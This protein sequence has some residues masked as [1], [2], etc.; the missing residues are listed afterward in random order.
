MDKLPFRQVHLDFH[1]SEYM[2]DVGSEFSEENFRN[3]LILGHISSITLFS[4]CHHGWSYHETKVNKMHPTLKTNLLK[5]QL[6]VCK[7]L[8]VRAQIYISAGL[9]ERKA[10]IYPEFR[11]E[12]RNQDNTLLGAHWHGLCLN[13]DN[14]ISMLKA[15][16]AEVM[17]DFK[18]LF[19]GIFIDICWPSPCVCPCCI[20]SMCDLGLNPENPDDVEKHRKIVYFKYTKILNSEILKHDKNMAVFYNCGNLPRNDRNVVYSNTQH[21]EL[22]SLPTGG[23]GYDHFPMSAAYSRVVGREFLGMTGKFHKSWGE[24]GGYKHPNALIYETALSIA[25]GAK[26]SI[27]DQLHP[28]GKFDEATYKLIGAAYSE[29]E[30]KE[31]WC[32]DVTAVA[33][34]AI[35]TTY[36][37]DTRNI[38]PDIGANRILLEGKYLYNIIDN[39]CDF[40]NYKIII[41][42]DCVM[43]DE[44][45]SEKT[46]IY[47]KN[48]GKIL[49]SGKSGLNHNDEFFKYFGIKYSGKSEYDSSYLIPAYNMMPNGSA[50]YLMYKRGHI[51]KSENEN[52]KIMAYMQ[53][54]YFNRSFR[55][56]CSHQNTPNDPKSRLPGAIIADNNIAYIAWDIFS[57]YWEHGAYHQKRIVCDIL[58][59]LLENNK[60]LETTLASNGVVTLMEQKKQKRY[61]NHLLYAVTKL[62]GNTEVI[63]DAAEIINTKVSIKLP[64]KPSRV[65]F[66]PD[67][68]DIP[69]TYENGKLS[70]TIDRF[71]LHGMVVIDK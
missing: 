67:N 25:N 66:A 71:V 14:Y 29:I 45:L 57:E 37:D 41:F 60:T 6:L 70:Y 30:K 34:I 12:V 33:D 47:L 51:I 43:F 50:P 8:G 5:R 22:E 69:Y 36:T 23:W 28:L 58:D 27:G 46:K 15:E 48:G 4:K 65:Y 32:G 31:K 59:I 39:Y 44:H 3:A 64:Q 10:V 40:S 52:V 61:V 56:F 24:F 54:S 7:E 68:I 1:T 13:N 42:P 11:S 35:Y 53:N 63:E 2:P 18:G 38:C 17:V 55:K 21:L 9:D 16:I 49:L 20:K 19:D 62:R 26:C